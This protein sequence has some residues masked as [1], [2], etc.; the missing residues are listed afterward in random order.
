MK[1]IC[2]FIAVLALLFAACGKHDHLE[3][4][5]KD[6]PDAPNSSTISS[7]SAPSSSSSYDVEVSSSSSLGSSSSEN[8]PCELDFESN[9]SITINTICIYEKTI[10]VPSERDKLN[11]L[12]IGSQAK[13]EFA[14]GASL[15]MN[16]YN[17]LNIAEGAEL[18]FGK[19]SALQIGNGTTLNI[20][21]SEENPVVLKAAGNDKWAGIKIDYRG[22]EP[23]NIIYAEVSG[24]D[25]GIDFG[26]TGVL[27]NCN[28]YNNGYGIILNSDF[29]EGKFSGNN[30]SSNEYDVWGNLVY[31]HSLGSSEQFTGKMHIKGNQG[32]SAKITLP[33]FTYFIDE[34]IITISNELKIEPG[35][36]FKLTDNS[37]FIA[38]NNGSIIAI[39]EINK[40]I[41][42]ESADDNT[43]W[44]GTFEDWNLSTNYAAFLFQDGTGKFQ[45]F[46][47]SRAKKAFVNDGSG[48][49]TLSDGQI[50]DFLYNDY[51]TN[52]SQQSG[53]ICELKSGISC[54]DVETN[55]YKE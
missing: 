11:E 26:K 45:H 3:D 54:P 52:G 1:K 25:V 49:V 50:T 27:E 41:T 16:N 55:Q 32:L 6:R 7:S 5:I 34:G 2:L 33:A 13:I 9:E 28:I 24:A 18:K 46:N 31:M 22:S 20:S 47:V 29:A 51:L 42:F 14:N 37:M 4:E 48:S 19:N 39:G 35:A 10:L 44:G 43:F 8:K 53:G 12:N 36:S 38:R 21:G 40:P 15:N 23:I 17:T 30:F